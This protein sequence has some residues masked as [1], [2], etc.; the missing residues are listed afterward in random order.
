MRLAVVGQSGNCQN[1]KK[2]SPVITT[3]EA[4]AIN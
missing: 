4:K 2:T 1:I 3:K